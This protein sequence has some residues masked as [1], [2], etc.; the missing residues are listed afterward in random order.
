MKQAQLIKLDNLIIGINQI[1][2]IAEVKE[3]ELYFFLPHEMRIGPETLVEEQVFYRSIRG[4]RFYSSAEQHLVNIEKQFLKLKQRIGEDYR[5]H[6]NLMAYQISSAIENDVAQLGRDLENTEE[7]SIDG[8]QLC[9]LIRHLLTQFRTLEPKDEKRFSYFTQADNY[10]S[11][12]G[13][14]QLL[15][16]FMDKS[17]ESDWTEMKSHILSLCREE[18]DYRIQKKYNTKKTIKN[19]NRISNKMVLLQR[20][21]QQGVVL[22]EDLKILGLGLKRLTTGVAMALVMLFI[23]IL[24]L[25][26]KNEFSNLTIAFV[27]SMALIYGLREIFK[28]DVKTV[29]WRR[30]QKG[31]P[32]WRR[33]LIDT[34]SKHVMVHE[35][36]W[37]EYL[38]PKDVPEIVSSILKARHNQNRLESQVLFYRLQS[39]VRA[40]QF[41]EGY[42]EIKEQVQIS[43]LPFTQYLHKGKAKLY[44]EQNG[45][46]EAQSV[47]R[48]Y[49]I[50]LI[51]AEKRNDSQKV[52]R[53]FKIT[54]NRERIV[55]ITE[56]ELGLGWF[57]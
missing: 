19:P 51:M 23:T 46:I 17:F 14:Q 9:D 47:E 29:L 49:Q 56:T 15:K 52:F 44:S 41:P 5:L 37:L 2:P 20:V 36:I 43:L 1:L 39:R 22:K 10:L 12:A 54:L 30:V 35:K 27:I 31:R 42:K 38:K 57:F 13:E 16:L 7:Q 11:W 8:K 3:L 18:N 50:N 45:E 32:K 33:Q 6:L 55:D 53:R 21:I 4:K 48:R 24:V 28:D 40:D 26:A 34:T 25:Q